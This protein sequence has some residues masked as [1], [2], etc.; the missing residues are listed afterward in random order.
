MPILRVPRRKL[1]P[2]FSL[3]WEKTLANSATTRITPVL[4]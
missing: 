4:W 2:C 3:S 1:Q